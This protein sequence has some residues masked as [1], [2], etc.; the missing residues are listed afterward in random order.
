MAQVY[1]H[2]ELRGCW[3]VLI[4]T[5]KINKAAV[6]GSFF[7]VLFFVYYST[8]CCIRSKLFSSFFFFFCSC[9]LIDCSF[10]RGLLKISSWNLII[11]GAIALDVDFFD[12]IYPLYKY[13][14]Q[15]GSYHSYN[16]AKC[17]WDSPRPYDMTWYWTVTWAQTTSPNFDKHGKCR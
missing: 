10:G 17:W 13:I 9:L 1:Y 15:E 5:G 6:F 8:M 7:L 3:G 11:V 4:I 2:G 14:M 16:R 12:H